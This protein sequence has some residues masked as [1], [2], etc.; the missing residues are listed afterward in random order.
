[1]LVTPLPPNDWCCVALHV[2]DVNLMQRA[3][4]GSNGS[5]HEQNWKHITSLK[6][7]PMFSIL[8]LQFAVAVLVKARSWCPNAGVETFTFPSWHELDRPGGSQWSSWTWGFQSTA[9]PGRS[10]KV[11]VGFV[12]RPQSCNGKICGELS[13]ISVSV[14]HSHGFVCWVVLF[15]HWCV[16]DSFRNSSKMPKK[17]KYVFSM[18]C[19]CWKD[20]EIQSGYRMCGGM[21]GK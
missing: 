10:T 1:M 20:W 4:N 21:W 19:F 12:E 14:G 3:P 6:H 9:S 16:Q 18:E 15:L 2:D 17:S 8:H 13:W 5:S 11:S 7:F